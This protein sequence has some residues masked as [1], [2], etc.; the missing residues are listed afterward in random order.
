MLFVES[1]LTQRNFEPNSV[2]RAELQKAVDEL[3]AAGPQEVPVVIDGRE[4]TSGKK[5]QQVNPGNHKQVLCNYYEADEA[6]VDT[7]IQGALK[8]KEVWANMPWSERA[9]IGLKAADLIANKYRYKLLAAT[10]VGQGKNVWQAE[11]DAGAEICDF[12]RFGVKYIHDMYS[13]QPPRNSPG[14]WNRTEYR[15]LEGFVFAVSPFNFTA[16]AGNLVMTP[17]LVGNVVVW[18]PSPMAIYSNYIVFQI[19]KEAGVPDGVIQFVPGDAPTV[20]NAA[21]NHRDFSSLHFTGSTFVF[22]SLWKQISNNLDLYQGYPRIVGETGGKNF[23]FVHPSANVD[24]VVTQCIRAAFEYQ[25]QKCSALSRL[26]VPKSLWEGGMKDKLVSATKSICLGPVNEFKHFMGP[27][28]AKHAFDKILGLIDE[29]KQQGG[30]VLTGG[31][32]DDSVGYYVQPTIIETTDPRSVTMVKEIFGPVITVYAYPDDEIDET[33]K[34]VDTTTEYALTGS[35]FSSDRQELL[36]VSNLL[37]NAS[38]MMYYNDKCTGAV[39]GQQPFGG[40]RASGTNDKAGSM[41][42]FFRFVSPRTIKESFLE[43]STY[44]YPSNQ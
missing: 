33:C 38:G 37:R 17:A 13:I 21:I 30:Q 8:A 32:G 9:A 44:I 15:P 25:G 4:F 36:R 27:V 3:I 31:T 34:L 2:D 35:I 6:M 22:R 5:S 40:A 26:Y 16:I 10:M 41:N 24:A 23:H 19:L 18:K 28:I 1:K 11:I 39:V 29:A 14:V 43:P 12:L 20:A 7:A 42:I